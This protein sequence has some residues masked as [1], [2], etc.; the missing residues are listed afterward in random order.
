MKYQFV[1]GRYI[2]RIN[3]GE[4]VHEAVVKFCTKQGIDNATLQ[5]IGA[6]D[7]IRCG[8]Y[9]LSDKTYEFKMYNELYEVVSYLGNVMRKDDGLFVHAHGSF[10]DE[11][12]ALFGG[13]V[14]E[15]RVGV[16]L[17]V[18]LTPLSSSIARVY[19]EET[20]LYLMDLQ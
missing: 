15:M 7:Q 14:D 19:D 20:G 10:G 12:G 9:H 4:N 16:V 3:R 6:I 13:H 8:Y 11:T 17:E 1:D 5:A 2:L 18:I